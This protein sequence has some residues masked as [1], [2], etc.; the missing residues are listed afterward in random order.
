M[1]I[2][3]SE[4]VPKPELKTYVDLP[5]KFWAKRPIEYLATLG[6]MGGYPDK[7]FRPNRALTRGELAAIL[8]K[9]KEFK[10]KPGVKVKFEDIRPKEWFAPYINVAASRNYMKGYPDGTFRPNQRV[11]RAEAA[12]IFAR[13]SGLYMKPKVQRKV[14]PDVSRKHWASPAIAASKQAGFF[15]YLGE[16][17]FGVEAYLTRAEAAEI[18]SKTPLVKEKIKE[19]ISGER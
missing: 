10:I 2:P 8:V 18:L 17:E 11:S 5:E 13:F 15:E 12:L 9:A 19:L 14:Y 16:E 1:A 4:V 6:I 7:T 3:L